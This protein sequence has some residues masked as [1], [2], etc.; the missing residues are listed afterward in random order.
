MFPLTLVAAIGLVAVHLF[1]GKLRFL[2][3]TPRSVWL[4]ASGGISVSYV[5]L[6]LLPEL[7]EGQTVIE[8]SV[9]GPLQTLEHHAYLIALAGL[10]S[11]Y[12]LERAAKVSREQQRRVER[13]DRP[14]PGVFWLHL[15]SFLL[16]NVL[17]GYLLVREA[18]SEAELLTFFIAMALHFV[19]T[20]YGLREHYKEQ[21]TQLGRW[22]L[23]IAVMTGWMLGRAVELPELATSMLVALLAGGVILNV[24]KEELPEERRSRFS[25]FLVGA[26]AYAALLLA[27]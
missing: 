13:R 20:D 15:V 25:A 17:I 3:G 5:F 12:G 16:Y 14:S 24:L 2:E 1:S 26:G 27:L 23:S 21:Y 18:R 22:I 4:S 11:F 10:T 7:A 9:A 19:V 6:H 8:G